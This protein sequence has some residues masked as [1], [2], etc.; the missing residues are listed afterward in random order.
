MQFLL[1]W[2]LG[3]VIFGAD[4][5]YICIYFQVAYFQKNVRKI[6]SDFF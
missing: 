4:C 1:D 5:H 2:G 3:L 6:I